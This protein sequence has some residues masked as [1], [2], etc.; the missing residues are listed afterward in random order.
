MVHARRASPKAEEPEL[1]VIGYQT[2]PAEVRPEPG[3]WRCRHAYGSGIAKVRVG[4]FGR[5]CVTDNRDGVRDTLQP[6]FTRHCRLIAAPL[7]CYADCGPTKTRFAARTGV[8]DGPEGWTGARVER[9]TVRVPNSPPKG[10]AKSAGFAGDFR[11][12]DR[13]GRTSYCGNCEPRY[14]SQGRR[15]AVPTGTGKKTAG[16]Q[17]ARC[18]R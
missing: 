3:R 9:P 1:V 7:A 5:L 13:T 11:A 12:V 10:G 6:C 18:E 2:P 4:R 15:G 16:A 8:Q 14:L 17:A